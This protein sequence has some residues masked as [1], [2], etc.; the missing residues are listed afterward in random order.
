MLPHKPDPSLFSLSLVKAAQRN[1]VLGIHESFCSKG[2]H[3]GVVNVGG[4]VTETHET[5]NPS[6]IASKTWEWFEQ[7]KNKTSFEV[8]IV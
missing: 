2:V 3:I 8:Q 6:N 5:L 4:Y 1:Q 7:S